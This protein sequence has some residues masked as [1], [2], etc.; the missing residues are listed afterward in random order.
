MPGEAGARNHAHGGAYPRGRT[1]RT[2]QFF[3]RGKPVSLPS[4][5]GDLRQH[6]EHLDVVKGEEP[7][8][9]QPLSAFDCDP[10]QTMSGGQESAEFRDAR[11]RVRNT[12]LQQHLAVRVDQTQLVVGATPVDAGEY[13]GWVRLVMKTSHSA[14]PSAIK[15]IHPVTDD[16]RQPRVR[17]LSRRSPGRCRCS[18]WLMHDSAPRR[19][20]GSACGPRR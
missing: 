9:E 20:N 5:G 12:A 17:T 11:D 8:D 10:G 2:R 3:R 19:P 16:A 7:L 18:R 13:I 4:A 14:V 6:A 15:R 1:R